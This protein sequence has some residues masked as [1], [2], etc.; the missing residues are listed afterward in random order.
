MLKQVVSRPIA[1][2]AGMDWDV[3]RRTYKYRLYPTKTQAERLEW[4]LA[5]CRELYNAALEERR[6]AYRRLGLTITGAQQKAQLPA[7]KEARP[8][9]REVG[10]QVLQDVLERLD[11]AFWSFFR[12][13]RAGQIAGYPRFRGR[14]RYDSLTYKQAGWKLK[15]ERLVLSGIGAFKVKWSRPIYGTVKTVTIKREAEQ[16]HVCFSCA[17]ERERWHTCESCGL[18]LQR[19]HNAARNI[20]QRAGLSRQATA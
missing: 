7:I 6:E 8:E 12:R 16:W 15:R 11:R 2:T 13:V 9:Y 1:Y 5:R 18:T 19:D 20:L 4:T 3:V 10:S 17:V 14:D